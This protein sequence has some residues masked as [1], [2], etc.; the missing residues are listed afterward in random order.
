MKAFLTRYK[1]FYLVLPSCTL[2][3]FNWEVGQKVVQTTSTN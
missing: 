3:L 2:R 1:A